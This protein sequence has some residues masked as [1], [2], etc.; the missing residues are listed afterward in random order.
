MSDAKVMY[1][2]FPAGISVVIEGRLGGEP[3]VKTVKDK[4]VIEFSIAYPAGRKKNDS[5]DWENYSE[6]AKFS[7]WENSV[8]GATD[9]INVI[10]NKP[11]EKLFFGKGHS[12]RF[13]GR[14]IVTGR[15][16]NG[17][18]Y[19]DYK[20]TDFCKLTKLMSGAKPTTDNDNTSDNEVAP[21]GF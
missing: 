15:E 4:R 1:S 17:K 9:L 10:E 6:W 5:G 13:E 8:S 19:V 11:S 2:M 21:N 18:A 20:V 14:V 3:V 7:V 16:Y 12:V